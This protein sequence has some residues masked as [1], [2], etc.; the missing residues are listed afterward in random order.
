[1]AWR[2]NTHDLPEAKKKRIG[3]TMDPKKGGGKMVHATRSTLKRI[4]KKNLIK[5][6]ARIRFED[7]VEWEFY[8]GAFKKNLLILHECPTRKGALTLI[9]G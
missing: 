1:M 2:Y 9:T 7:P 6:P 8:N 4:S 5:P 3:E